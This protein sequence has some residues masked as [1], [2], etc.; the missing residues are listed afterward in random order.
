MATSVVN[1][2]V[3][4]FANNGRPL[5]GGRIHTYVAGSSTRARTYKDAAKVQP[6]TNPIILDARGEAAIYLA[7]GVEYKFVIEDSKGALIYT[8]EPVY[9]AIWPN[10]E[11]WPSDATLSYQYMNE[12]K[13]AAG[14][15]GPIKFY[16]TYAQALGDI[17]SIPADGLVEVFQDEN[18]TGYRTR[19]RK[20]S[21]VLELKIVFRE[22]QTYYL[23]DFGLSDTSTAQENAVA[24]EKAV[25]SGKKIGPLSKAY[26][27]QFDGNPI[28]CTNSVLDIDL[29]PYKHNFINF[30]G[31]IANSMFAL[32]Y[33]GR[34]TANNGYCKGIGRFRNLQRLEIGIIEITDVFCDTP[35]PDTQFFGLEYSSN[36]YTDNQFTL[37]IGTAV[38]KNIKTRTPNYPNAI[39]MTGIGNFG[40]STAQSKF[41]QLTIGNLHVEDFYS[42][43]PTDGSVVGGDSDFFRLFTNP[44]NLTIDNCRLSNVGKRFIKTQAETNVTVVNL[45]TKLDSR[46]TTLNYNGTFEGQNAVSG[47]VTRFTVL[48][49]KVDYPVSVA[50]VAFFNANGLPHEMYLHSVEFKGLGLL[51]QSVDGV[52]HIRSA[53]GD[54]FL[55]NIPNSSN[56]ILDNARIT[57]FYAANAIGSL[58]RD[59]QIALADDAVG[60]GFPFGSNAKFSNVE[61]TNWDTNVRV[62]QFLSLRGVSIDYTRGTASR[63]PFWPTDGA[64]S[65]FEN[66]SKTGLD[67][68]GVIESPGAGTSGTVV[69]RGYRSTSN[70]GFISQ[71]AWTFTLDDCN[72]DVVIGAGVT[73]VSRAMYG[74]KLYT[75]TATL[76]FGSIPAGSSVERSLSVPGVSTTSGVVFASPQAVLAAGLSWCARI[77]AVDTVVVRVSNCTT[78]ALTPAIVTWRV[79]ALMH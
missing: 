12:A 60:S 4:F 47:K 30:G 34:F 24:F 51:M 43:N 2:R 65:Y 10:A 70:L 11:Q 50:P 45:D 28:E 64:T 39:P 33:N 59:S 22:T 9:G 68:P 14:A 76:D 17:G 71:G 29:G 31:I 56:F 3:Q 15:I 37:D 53:K 36:T 55:A 23:T 35:T 67:I 26:S 75:A 8:Q 74:A 46:F 63:R 5:I 66:V 78:G 40:S 38:F 79:D 27:F 20:E 73:S 77:S 21:G 49:A 16:D 1:P 42:V 58:I 7:E 57:R 52:L 69:C 19:Y 41:H 25:K 6:N 72:S 44:T 61:L 62:V 32:R 13:A 48:N 18:H 54:C